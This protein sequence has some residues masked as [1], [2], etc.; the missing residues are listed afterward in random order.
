[1]V[2]APLDAPSPAD[3]MA[4]QLVDVADRLCREFAPAGGAGADAVRRQVREA[5]EGFGSPTVFDYLPVLVERD[6][7]HRLG[8]DRR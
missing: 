4:Q 5:R 7:R 1:M 8:P 2:R 6:V 3:R